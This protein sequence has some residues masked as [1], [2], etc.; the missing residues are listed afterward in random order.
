VTEAPLVAAH[1]LRIDVGGAIAIER[2]TF[3][4]RGGSVALLGDEH[5]ILSAIAGSAEVR[6]GSLSILGI[7]VVGGSHLRSNL[8]GMAALDPPLPPRWT[9][10]EYLLWGARLGG[11]DRATAGRDADAGLAQ[12]GLESAAG[13]K[14]ESLSL[15]ERR[16]LV[17][18]QAVIAGPA[19]L[20]ASGPLS[21]LGGRE[22]AYVASAWA[23][24][25]RGRKWIVSLSN[26]YLGSAESVLAQSADDLLLFASGRLVRQGKLDRLESGAIGYT[27]TVRS[28]VDDL[29]TALRARGV[30][31]TGGPKRFFVELPQ[32]MK[33]QDL[34][35][36]SVDIGAPIVELVPRIPAPP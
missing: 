4:S 14:L 29:R 1:D 18:A 2:A 34:L 35:A 8:V 19:V 27:I 36:L 25:A 32:E 20:V 13:Q 3:A 33:A 30:E 22:A 26:L 21:G 28:K 15:I 31:L 12:F 9:A 23:T 16:V 7:E 10:R 17:L 6:A 11:A 24:A 5:G